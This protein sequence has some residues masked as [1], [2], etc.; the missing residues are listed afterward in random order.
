MDKPYIERSEAMEKVERVKTEFFRA[1]EEIGHPIKEGQG[2][3]ETFSDEQRVKEK[4][5]SYVWEEIER[6]YNVDC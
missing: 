2:D 6:V 1:M 4:I 5:D 3:L